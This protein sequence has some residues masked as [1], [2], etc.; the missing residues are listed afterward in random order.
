MM[1]R[2]TRP[3]LWLGVGVTSALALATTGTQAQTAADAQIKA[4]QA[5]I[6]QLQKALNAVA[7][8]QAQIQQ[9]QNTVNTLAAQQAQD[10]A[11]A[12]AAQAQAAQAQ[13]QA[14]Q[15]QTQASQAQAQA[16]QA[17]AKAGT[18]EL[19][20]NG[21]GFLEH[22]KG[23]A[24]TF[25]T[26]GG[27]ITGYGNID[28]SIDAA[29]KSLGSLPSAGGQH[30][31]GNFG[32]MPD[33][34]TNNAYLGVRGFQTLGDHPFRFVYQFEA[35]IDVSAFP[36]IK[37]SGSSESNQVNGAL[38]S[39]N[40]YIGLDNAS[41]GAIKIGKS[42]APYKNSTAAL[43]PFA[44]EIG[45]Y[46]VIMGNTGG[47]NRVEFGTRL[48][49]AIWYESPKF[50]GGFT[51]NLLFSPGQ[52][53]ASD[54][55]NLAAGESDCAGSD[56]PESGGDV[57][58]AC[59]DG[60]FSNVVSTN[61]AYTNGPLYL[62]MAGELHNNV[63]RQSDITAIYGAG[64]VGALTPL[65]QSQFT[66]DVADEW[67]AKVAAQYTFPTK[68]MVG[69]I[70][71]YLRRD[72]PADL[73]F[74]NERT[75]FGTWLVLGQTVTPVDS[76]FFG[77]AHAFRTPGDPGQHN[78]STIVTPDGVGTYA[79]NNNSADMLTLAWKHMFTENLTWYADWATTINGPSAHYDL[80]AG[81]RSVT[82]DC[83]D[84]FSASGGA[85]S[86]PH[87]WTGVTLMGVST[88]LKWTF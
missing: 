17:A 50:G 64:T 73:D 47:D 40:T 49:H 25:Y 77:W 53:R 45:D 56:I 7:P 4:L 87:C 72:V 60:A 52:N 20:K 3:S 2:G 46:A 63:N 26:P 39:R 41:W 71:E 55:D 84:A 59:N 61:L 21:H 23:D 70:V 81:G 86:T 75:R 30:P 68:T 32:W 35:G 11:Q 22:K 44:G 51:F 10:A 5:Q 37:E 43:N 57:P 65:E 33:I 9:L 48:S 34:S 62:T 78:D 67:A 88:G 18:A 15:A 1:G 80:G 85:F 66:Q 27:E 69:G 82:T 42:D 24:L 74:Q 14:S 83:H 6:Q 13:T 12:K 31:V 8:L 76:V 79:S 54:S 16:A 38:F 36:G 58:F 28:V 19:D 29:T